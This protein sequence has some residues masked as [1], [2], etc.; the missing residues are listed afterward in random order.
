MIQCRR[1]ELQLYKMR[2]SSKAMFCENLLMLCTL[3][4]K[5]HKLEEKP[6][7]NSYLQAKT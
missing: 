3:E 4:S 5:K 2:G 7:S 1:K 6:L